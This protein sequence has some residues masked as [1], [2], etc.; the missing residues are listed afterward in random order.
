MAWWKF[1]N[2]FKKTPKPTAPTTGGTMSGKALLIGIN[3]YP[4]SPL[5]GCINDVNNVWNLLMQNYGFQAH[6]ICVLKDKDATTANILAKLDWLVD[7]KP[8]DR[9][10]FH[11]SGHGAQVAA[12]SSAN[13][14]DGLTEIICP[15]DF[16]WTPSRMITDDQFV[17]IFSRMPNGI[18]FNWISDSCHSGDLD[19]R[20]PFITPVTCWLS[21]VWNWIKG[22]PEAPKMTPKIMPMP[23]E[24][25][26]QI[27]LAKSR[28]LKIKGMTGGMLDVGY[29]SG[30]QSNQTS[31][32]TEIDGSACGALTFF[33]VKNLKA[34][35]KAPLA[36]VV[37]AVNRE[38]ASNGYSQRPQVGGARANKPFL[39]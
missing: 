20:M 21:K 38:L 14:P 8:G 36:D 17:K 30:C 24:I 12:T 28:G 22:T 13:E 25:S 32:D 33:L 7:V 10:L 1:W 6:E 4:S 18:S 9:V 23:G 3:A 29:I 27:R 31:S 26:L 5:A 11:Y 15:V 35:P 16:N 39:G 34:M 37:A 2:W 19:R